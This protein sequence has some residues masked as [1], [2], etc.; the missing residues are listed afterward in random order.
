MAPMK[1][2]GVMPSQPTRS[3]IWSCKM[4]NVDHVVVP[5]MP[6]SKKGSRSD[7]FLKMNPQG[8]IPTIDDDGVILFEAVGILTYLAEK[9]GWDDLYPK[10]PVTRG[11][12][13]QYI[14]WHNAGFGGRS[15]TQQTFAPLARPDLKIPAA[16]ILAGQKTALRTLSTFEQILG[17]KPFLCGD[18]ATLADIIAYGDIGQ[19]TPEYCDLVDFSGHPKARAWCDR[20][21][22][23]PFHDECM[24]PTKQMG[25]KMFKPAVA[26]LKAEAASKM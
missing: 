19:T 1:I 18:N 17:D 26:K 16:T 6:G 15:I 8:A 10:D 14:S 23:L 7:D 3:V 22:K 2:Y 9:H 25:E 12:I 24:E 5:T 20:M 11:K 4:K 21:K 13:H